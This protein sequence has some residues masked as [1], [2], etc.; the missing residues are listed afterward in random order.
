MKF[1]IINPYH[2]FN[3]DCKGINILV[4]I[5]YTFSPI[6]STITNPITT[7]RPRGNNASNH[8]LTKS[9]ITESSLKKE[10]CPNRLKIAQTNNPVAIAL[11]IPPAPNAACPNPGDP[12][13]I[14]SGFN[15]IK[16]KINPPHAATILLLLNLFLSQ[17]FKG[18]K[19]D[20]N[21]DNKPIVHP[22]KDQNENGRLT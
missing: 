11:N 9:G 18:N 7:T 8:C 22:N 12:S 6:I 16:Y 13:S 5:E 4:M 19:K 2:V 10:K 17:K 14:N 15:V 20:T 1:I 21:T 3:A